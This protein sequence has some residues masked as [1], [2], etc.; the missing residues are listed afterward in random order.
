MAANSSAE[1]LK[2][3]ELAAAIREIQE[4]V[5]AQHPSGGIAG[6]SLGVPLPDLMPIVHARDAAEA[7][8]AA[9]GTVNPRP[10]GLVH[11]AIQ[12]GKRIISRALGWFVRD[13][14]EYNRA[15]MRC[16]EALLEALG[17]SNRSI[18]TMAGR[19]DEVRRDADSSIAML[20]EANAT[21]GRQLAEAAGQVSDLRA[22]WIQ[23]REEWDRKLFTNEVQFL[24]SVADL[25]A[26]FS[27]RATI[28]EQ[29]FRD[30]ANWQHSQFTAAVEKSG[31]DIQ[32]RL[33]VDLERIRLD[34]ERIIHSE[35]RLVRQRASLTR[36]QAGPPPAPQTT[37]HFPFDYS[38]FAEK[39]RGTEEYVRAKQRFY[40]PYFQGCAEAVDLG[41]GR[42]EFLEV[43]REAGIS[44]RGIDQDRESVELCRSKGLDAQAT[45][46]FTFLGDLAD[47]GV[48]GLY[49]SQVIEH[50]PTERLPELI[51]LAASKLRR[52]GVIALET[53][54]PECLAI[55]STHFFLDPT[56]TR[57]I[58]PA[59]LAFYLEEFGFG[60]IEVHRQSPA[61]ES[62]PSLESLPADFREAFFGFLDYAVTARKL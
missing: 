4:R 9:I 48:D 17:E 61:V 22:H 52:G 43:L 38:K 3:A 46:L 21:L 12:N 58:P 29:N 32:Q 42:G 50:L 1:D 41:C 44:A 5:R 49:A 10:S 51:K 35:L 13:Q 2:A 33:W 56:H 47:G 31:A 45:D 14:V 36:P 34:Y 7:K 62:M 20:R 11:N 57:P 37:A 26:G 27:H 8:V 19:L 18:S 25:Q 28:M 24:R 6:G 54:N 60:R 15:L 55:F 30:T 39:F 16:V 23:W 40:I 59:L 53:P